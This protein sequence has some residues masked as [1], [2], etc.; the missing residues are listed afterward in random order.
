MLAACRRRTRKQLRVP[1][2]GNPANLNKRRCYCDL[3]ERNDGRSRNNGRRRVHHYTERAMI[4]V[5]VCRVRVRDLR[6][7]KQGQQSQTHQRHHKG[8]GP[9]A[10]SILK[11][12][13]K[14]GKQDPS[15]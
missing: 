15:T 14:S 3:D 12:C 2:A 7:G 1:M 8:A 11:A 13:L 4:G 5:S 10:A 9:F 6:Y